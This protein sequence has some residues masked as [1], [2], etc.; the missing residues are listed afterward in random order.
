MVSQEENHKSLMFGRE[1]K[2][3]NAT[4]FAVKTTGKNAQSTEKTT[5]LHCGR[6]GHKETRCFELI[7]YPVGWGTRGITRLDVSN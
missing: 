2:G 4:A 1:D 7:G 3:E 5:C 6:T